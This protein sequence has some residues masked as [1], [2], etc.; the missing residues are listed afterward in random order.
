MTRLRSTIKEDRLESLM[1]LNSEKDININHNLAIDTFAA[2]S[3]LL[4]DSL[5]FK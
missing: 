5:L 2:K 1:I 4:K 3:D